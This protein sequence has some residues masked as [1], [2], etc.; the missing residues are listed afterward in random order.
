MRKLRIVVVLSVLLWLAAGVPCFGEN[1]WLIRINIPEFKLYL[2]HAKEIYQTFNVA[3]GKQD[4]PSPL[5]EFWIVNKVL[6]PTWYPPD[7]RIPVPAG[8]NNPLGKYWIGLNIE[9]YGIHG[10]SAAW[11]IGTPA[12]LGCFRLHNKDIKKIFELAPIGTPVQIIYETVK[13]GIGP[14]NMAWVEVFPDIYKWNKI[15]ME[16]SKAIQGLGWIYEPHWRALGELLK[17]KKPLKVEVP[18]VIKVLGE[19]MDIDGFYWQQEVYIARKCLD[20]LSIKSGAVNNGASFNGY[21]KL[22]TAYF[23]GEGP[24]YFWDSEA[25]TLRIIRL[26]VLLNGMELSNAACFSKDNQVLVNLKSVATHLGAKFFWDY[27]SK[28]FI[29]NGVMIAGEPREGGF[30]VTSEELTQIWQGLKWHWNR[31]NATLKLQIDQ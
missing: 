20:V 1:P 5:G 29:C 9:G 17:A 25:N 19:S 13:A 23:T 3:V 14:N 24:Q 7:G 31:K 10:N 18:R 15:E 30:W 12:S 27:T 11:S 26:K 4:T 2:Y 22:D 6:D 8:P 28:V 16:I 21:V